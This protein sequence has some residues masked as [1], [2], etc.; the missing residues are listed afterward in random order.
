[1]KNRTNTITK[2]GGKNREKPSGADP[3]CGIISRTRKNTKFEDMKEIIAITLKFKWGDLYQMIRDQ[4]IPNA[5][6]E[7]ILFYRNIKI[8]G[9]TKANIHLDLFPYSEVLG[10]ILP[11]V[12]SSLSIIFIVKGEAFSSFNPT[13]IIV[14]YKLPS[15]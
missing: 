11:R 8:S 3:D 7:K 15:P 13:Y 4:N 10:W 1:M 12:N 5:G 9:I 14:A 6:L 2:K